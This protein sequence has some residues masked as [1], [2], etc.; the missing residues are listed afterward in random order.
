[1]AFGLT[2][3]GF[4]LKRLEDIK[5]EIEID[6]REAFGEINVSPDSVFGQII[7]VM[8]R[9]IA[10]IWEQAESIYFSFYPASAE[11]Y[12]LDGVAQLNGIIRL[13]ST[14]SEVVCQCLG[15]QGTI[16]PD[17]T[18]VGQSDQG[19]IFEQAGIFVITRDTQHRTVLTVMKDDDGVYTVIIDGINVN[20]TASGNTIVEI[21]ENLS[22]NINAATTVNDKVESVYNSGEEF[23]TV[24]I[25]NEVGISG[26]IP[27]TVDRNYSILLASPT[28]NG[29][30]YTEL[31]SPALYRSVNAGRFPVPIGSINTIETPI[32][33]F[34]SV[35]NFEDGILGRDPE[36]D[37]ELR[38]RR[39]QSLQI[40]GAATIGAIKARVGQE[41]DNVVQVN[42]IENRTDEWIPPGSSP[43][44]RP[45]HSIE[46]VVEGGDD[47]EIAEKIW[48]VKAAGIQTYGNTTVVIIDSNG[49]PQEIR[50]SRPTTV[51]LYVRIDYDK[52]DA[53]ESFPSDGEDTIRDNI[54]ALGILYDIGEDVI[55]Q[56]FFSS[57]YSI[58]GI[59]DANIYLAEDAAP[60]NPSPSWVQ[61]NIII[62]AQAVAVF[63]NSIT[64]I[65]LNDV[66]P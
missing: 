60:N 19:K 45:P 16:I 61:S 32:S 40:A 1:M 34:S 56:R 65:V 12:S 38:T 15:T 14:E 57:V 52:T 13:A 51:H 37:V 5:S 63:E 10:E 22:S 29:I 23:F 46:V 8:S 2:D 42:V 6:L 21:A 55:R 49:D 7:G 64:R 50:F 66:T 3:D 31:Y 30:E 44:G 53:E 58:P 27:L 33:G 36:T 4:V 20:F 11:G 54:Y 35:T 26:D 17:L 18:K 41:V 47:T 39:I 48:Q 59:T 25:K 9:H 24:T 62:S 28:V 43:T